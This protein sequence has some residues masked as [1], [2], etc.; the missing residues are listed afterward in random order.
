MQ[1]EILDKYKLTLNNIVI[2]YKIK[3]PSANM[4]YDY[5]PYNSSRRFISTYIHQLDF[6]DKYTEVEILSINFSSEVC[7]SIIKN[8]YLIMIEG[9]TLLTIQNVYCNNKSGTLMLLKE[10]DKYRINYSN[11]NEDNEGSSF[12][13]SKIEIERLIILL[14]SDDILSMYVTDEED[15]NG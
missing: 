6:I 7:A 14:E 12:I 10:N 15:E 3:E 1:N 2:N 4:D 13:F 8:L 9:F 5:D 11:N